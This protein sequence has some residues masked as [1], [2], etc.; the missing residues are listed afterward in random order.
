MF[1]F[2]LEQR[3]IMNTSFV[4]GK[5]CLYE[6]EEGDDETNSST[7]IENRA[8]STKTSS[9]GS[10]NSASS[11]SSNDG[12]NSSAIE[13]NPVAHQWQ[14]FGSNLELTRRVMEY[15][16]HPKDLYR[17]SM[18]SKTSRE[19]VTV[20][21][22]VRCAM[23]HGGKAYDTM[24]N[25]HYLMNKRAI[26]PPSPLRLLRLI[27]GKRCE[28][29]NNEITKLHPGQE[30]FI[31]MM[32]DRDFFQK[33]NRHNRS[34]PCSIGLNPH[35]RIV[36]KNFGVFACYRCMTEKRPQHVTQNRP[37][38]CLT[39]LWERQSYNKKSGL[40]YHKQFYLNNRVLMFIIFNNKQVLAYSGGKRILGLNRTGLSVHVN[41]VR[42]LINPISNGMFP[43]FNSLDRYEIVQAS[44]LKDASGDYIGSLINYDNIKLLTTYLK[45]SLED[46]GR[47][48]ENGHATNDVDLSDE[49]SYYIYNMIESPPSEETFTVFENT[50]KKY[51][52]HASRI[53]SQQL[54]QSKEKKTLAAYN[55]IERTINAISMVVERITIDLLQQGL[56]SLNFGQDKYTAKRL[57]RPTNKDV[58][59]VRRILL[60]YREEHCSQFRYAVTY[61]TGCRMLNSD[62]QKWLKPLLSNPGAVLSGKVECTSIAYAMVVGFMDKYGLPRSCSIPYV[63]VNGV[64]ST[65]AIGHSDT[66]NRQ[67]RPRLK[68]PWRD[69]SADRRNV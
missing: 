59:V 46:Q 29:C 14:W 43:Y 22:V 3:L 52:W 44:Y 13:N 34:K 24:K 51:H 50:F 5:I 7:T 21:I 32:N 47:V 41:N 53:R 36:R 38:P 4:L 19:A 48:V 63:I 30:S 26:Y 16:Q 57:L 62:M 33:Y 28:F 68:G 11:N 2:F 17:I 31:D 55:R 45:R 8:D 67:R 40:Y 56:R 12:D 10:V 66:Y 42:R 9:A 15:I 18:L 20:E 64:I 35:P 27:F 60:R 39:R 23:T 69:K 37:Y 58:S 49:I 61:N 1:F 25:I 6:F 65:S 54:K